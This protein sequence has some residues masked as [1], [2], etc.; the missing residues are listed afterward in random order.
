MNCLKENGFFPD[1]S[2]VGKTDI[3]FFCNPNNPT[4]ACATREQLT[5][6]V[7]FARKNGS[8]IV[9]DAAYA[10]YIED[11]A[12]KSIFEIEGADECCIETCSFSKYV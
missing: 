4:G 10:I 6:L 2:K 11:G 5:E 3:I 7:A 12:P 8:I 1:L 9:Y